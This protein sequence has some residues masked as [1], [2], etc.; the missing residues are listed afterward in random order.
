MMEDERYDEEGFAE[1][2]GG[3]QTMGILNALR[4]G[5]PTLDMLLAMLLPF[6]IR[7]LF[8]FTSRFEEILKKNF[9]KTFR[10]TEPAMHQRVIQYSASSNRYGVSDADDSQNR[11]LQKAVQ[12]YLHS[13]MNLDLQVADIN[14]T[15]IETKSMGHRHSYYDDEYEDEDSNH[16]TL[17]GSL[18]KYKI[19]KNPP[20]E[21][22]HDLGS[23]SGEEKVHSKVELFISKFDEEGGGDGSGGAK[24]TTTLSFQFKSKDG[25]SIDTFIDSA[26]SWYMNELSKMEDHSRY[27]YELKSASYTSTSDEND[28]G[29]RVYKRYRL[30]DEKTFDSLFFREKETILNL[31]HNFTARTGKYA[32]KG[33]PHKLGLLLHGPPGTGKTSLI[34]AVAQYT[35]RSIINVS[36]TRI[37]TN[38][39]LMSIFFDKTMH[40]DGEYVPTKLKFKDVI[41]VIEDVDVASR[42]VKRRDGKKTA[43]MVQTDAFDL[44]SSAKSPMQ[45]LLESG[46]E[47]AKK[48]VKLLIEKS[49]RLRQEALRPDLMRSAARRMRAL[50]GLSLVGEAID[51]PALEKIGD[52]AIKVGEKI[53]GK[54][55]QVDN[56]VGSHAEAILRMLE[57]SD[58]KEVDEQFENELL[59]LS[60]PSLPALAP[61]SRSRAVSF[62]K[63]G[64]D[65]GVEV[66]EPES[67]YLSTDS[68]VKA[69]NT[70]N[71]SSAK[72]AGAYGSA[73]FRPLDELNLQGLLNVLD[74]VVD[75]PG[76]IVIMTTNH[77]E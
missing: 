75:S 41:Y 29:R 36:L 74:G 45:L 53:I 18:S 59:G 34:K 38:A 5:D 1:G 28:G 55:S 10:K 70:T 71:G 19:V 77:P 4:T 44:P 20:K 67:A 16:R 27:L 47:H 24:K 58:A 9:W 25:K 37:E 23:F 14:L 22:W 7:F 35:G 51:N 56:I 61:L 31:M 30:S 13:Q 50:P 8:G 40:V 76:R 69:A 57:A 48:L 64:E 6:V 49:E 21:R 46:N 15:S 72:A 68:S 2:M 42:I 33:Y 11:V 65:N 60:A 52:D 3:L 66:S 39:D 12:L 54:Q 62:S 17:A 63:Y 32:I 26:Y 73:Y 43:D